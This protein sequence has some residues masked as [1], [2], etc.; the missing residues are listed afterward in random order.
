MSPKITKVV[1]VK[2]KNGNGGFEGEFWEKIDQY[3]N[4]NGITFPPCI[5]KLL[6]GCGYESLLCFEG[7][8]SAELDNIEKFTNENRK[9]VLNDL[10]CC[11]AEQYKKQKVFSFLPGQRTQ[12]SNFELAEI[13]GEVFERKFV[14]HHSS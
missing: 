14:A 9:D 10:D 7:M 3:S 1:P 2:K 12:I 4:I 8:N 6:K 13:Y 11:K 5:K